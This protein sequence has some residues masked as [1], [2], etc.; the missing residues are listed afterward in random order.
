MGDFF[1]IAEKALGPIL[2]VTLAKR[3]NFLKHHPPP[4]KWV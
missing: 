1:L 3:Y 2:P 4:V